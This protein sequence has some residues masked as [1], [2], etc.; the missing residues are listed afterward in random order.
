MGIISD[1][2]NVRETQREHN[3][4]LTRIQVLKHA[5][6]IYAKRNQFALFAIGSGLVFFNTVTNIILFL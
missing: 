6:T 4:S 5:I 3:F 2:K 1:I